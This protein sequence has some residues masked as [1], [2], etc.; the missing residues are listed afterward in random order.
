MT[1]TRPKNPA[2][3]RAAAAAAAPS[4]APTAVA[5]DAPSAFASY[6]NAWPDLM[7][8]IGEQTVHDLRH[9]AELESDEVQHL[10]TPQDLWS[11]QAEFA[12][13]V[14]MRLAR[15]SVQLA[16]TML[17]VQ[18]AWYRDAEARWAE[19]MRPWLG[20]GQHP[21]LGSA[22][23]LF[24]LPQ[25]L[26]PAQAFEAMQRFWG[27]STKLWFNAISHDLQGGAKAG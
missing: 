7:R 13:E 5:A 23:S 2:R 14:W 25:P 18:S 20:D 4:A 22:Q 17:D 19:T 24:D 6:W 21:V 1:R 11:R 8:R 3:R 12:G 9:D 26:P 10:S 16:A 15:S 27:E